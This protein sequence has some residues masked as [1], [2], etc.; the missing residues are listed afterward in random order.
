MVIVIFKKTSLLSIVVS[1]G[2]KLQSRDA[3]VQ[4]GM[5]PNSVL[6]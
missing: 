6:N 4:L 5:D 3:T 2:I 1:M